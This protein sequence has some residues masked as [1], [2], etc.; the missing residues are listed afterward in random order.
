MPTPKPSNNLPMYKKD[1][2]QINIEV[3]NGDTNI[4]IWQRNFIISIKQNYLTLANEMES[5]PMMLGIAAI[6]KDCKQ[7]QKD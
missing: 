1:R 6:I 5:Q 7:D 4:A 3:K 2:S